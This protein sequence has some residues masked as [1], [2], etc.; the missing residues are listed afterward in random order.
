MNLLKKTFIIAFLSLAVHSLRACDVCGCGVSASF[1]GTLPSG[2]N[3]FLGLRYG[4]ST[5]DASVNYNSDLIEDEYSHDTFHRTELIGRFSIAKQLMLA[6]NIPYLVNRA[7]GYPDNHSVQGIGDASVLLYFKPDL[8]KELKLTKHMLFLGAGVELPLGEHKSASDGQTINRN[9]QLG[10]G[11][12]D[13]LFS[14]NYTFRKNN[15][16]LNLE[17]SVK[18]NTQAKD[19]Y[20]FGSQYSLNLSGL[21]YMEMDKFSLIGFL[22][23]YFESSGAHDQHGV[24]QTNTGGSALFTTT[25]VQIF[26]RKFTFNGQ[27]Q[28]PLLQAY[29]TDRYSNISS[30]NRFSVGVFY[31]FTTSSM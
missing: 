25:G 2:N 28:W 18:L 29:E 26:T 10:S 21:Y 20:H 7:E 5:F 17:S 1:F 15:L 22:G 30:N 11:S 23:S 31:N 12:Y 4:Y 9:F 3:H 6:S 19:G 14:G 27:Y 16:G 24:T 8:N 13:F